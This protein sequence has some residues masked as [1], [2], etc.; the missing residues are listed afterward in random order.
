MIINDRE[1]C[2]A[3]GLFL[4]IQTLLLSSLGGE[5]RKLFTVGVSGMSVLFS[6]SLSSAGVAGMSSLLCSLMAAIVV[7]E[8]S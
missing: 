3:S 2:K 4:K 1:D 6:C 8:V 7:Q 5:E